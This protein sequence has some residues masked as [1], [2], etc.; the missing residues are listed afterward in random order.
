M[1]GM[2]CRKFDEVVHGFVRMELLDVALREEA[3]DHIA[4]CSDCT[5]RMAEATALAEATMAAGSNVHG[6]QAP[7]SVEATVLAAFRGHHRRA[8]WRRTFEWSAIGAA[9]AM[10]L[11]FLWTVAGP[12][13]GRLSPSPRRDVSSQSKEPLDAKGPVATKPD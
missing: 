2:T 4:H 1:S 8:V 7:P 3:L 6:Q 9:A 12:S 5:E 11:V 10:A 13:R